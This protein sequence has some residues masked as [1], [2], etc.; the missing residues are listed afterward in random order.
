MDK[1]GNPYQFIVVGLK[2][3]SARFVIDIKPVRVIFNNKKLCLKC[4]SARFV[5][6]M[7]PV[8]VS[9]WAGM[10]RSQMPFG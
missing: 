9:S 6:D 8:N 1:K 2:C 7:L 10:E 3:L 5:I 4:L